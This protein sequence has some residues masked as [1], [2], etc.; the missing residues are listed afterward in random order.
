MAETMKLSDAQEQLIQV[1]EDVIRTHKRVKVEKS[2]VA[3]AG[4]VS[5]DDLERLEQLDALREAQF[6]ALKKWAEPFNNRDSEEIE[7]EARKAIAEVREEMR[8]SRA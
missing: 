4:I 2:G 6:E 3:V 7:E 1:V 5:V 8:A